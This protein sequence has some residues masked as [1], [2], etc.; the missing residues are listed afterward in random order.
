MVSDGKDL[1]NIA[2]QYYDSPPAESWTGSVL[3]VCGMTTLSDAN[4]GHFRPGLQFSK[5]GSRYL[6]I[7]INHELF[8]HLDRK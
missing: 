8:Y 2:M 3:R 6:F 4:L 7:E 1:T 5:T